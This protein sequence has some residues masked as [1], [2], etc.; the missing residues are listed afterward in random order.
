MAH[1]FTF[2]VA[3]P[4][5]FLL[6]GNSEG[7]WPF[8]KLISAKTAVKKM[9][10]H[11]VTAFVY[12]AEGTSFHVAPTLRPTIPETPPR[13]TT[14]PWAFFSNVWDASDPGDSRN[15]M[16]SIIM[17]LCLRPRQPR[18]RTWFKAFPSLMDAYVLES[19]RCA[20]AWYGPFHLQ[21]CGRPNSKF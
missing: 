12:V 13:N 3:S 5:D 21:R 10:S 14:L 18:H 1:I 8:W 6:K 15:M 2:D 16:C 19:G 20:Y 11:I 9:K 4:G 7:F 17:T